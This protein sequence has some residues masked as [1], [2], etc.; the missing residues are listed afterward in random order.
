MALRAEDIFE[1]FRKTDLKF[2]ETHREFQE[3]KQIVRDLAAQSREA[4]L[5][6]QETKQIVKELAVSSKETDRKF[7][8]TD[9]KFQESQQAFDRQMKVLSKSIGDI[10]NRL[11]Q[12]VEEMIAPAV[13]PLFQARGIEVHQINQRHTAKREGAVAEIDLFVVNSTQAVAV[14]VK[15]SLSIAYVDK[16]L[17]TLA[18]I[19][20]FFPQYAG[21]EVFGA[22]AAM[23]VTAEVAQYAEAQGLF[24]LQPSGEH[25]ELGNAAGFS[26]KS[27]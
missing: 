23:V 20:W 3:T 10:G 22:V 7:Q 16:H 2:Q 25:I 13:V 9:R 4:D 6:F 15:S 11:G 21:Y 24:V 19:K 18:R 14:E 27:W 5:S 1:L 8:E 17:A 26:P 12:F